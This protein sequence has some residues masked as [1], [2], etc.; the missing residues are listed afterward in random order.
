M[1]QLLARKKNVHRPPHVHEKKTRKRVPPQD[2]RAATGGARIL[3]LR[4]LFRWLPISSSSGRGTSGG[5]AKCPSATYGDGPLSSRPEVTRTPGHQPTLPGAPGS[6]EDDVGWPPDGEPWPGSPGG[7]GKGRAP[8][9]GRSARAPRRC[10][11]AL[12]VR[13][14]CSARTVARWGGNRDPR[15]MQIA[16]AYKPVGPQC[17]RP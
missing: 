4:L 5:G 11:A 8:G 14:C 15:R 9:R 3:P 6:G 7:G 12:W 17:V 2:E 10:P 16:D 13:W 1:P